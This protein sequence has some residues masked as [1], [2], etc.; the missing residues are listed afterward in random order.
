MPHVAIKLYPGRSEQQKAR[1]CDEIVK[2]V[3]AALQCGEQ[4]I[5]VSIE[6]IEQGDWTVKVYEPDILGKWHKL[7]KKP[8]YEPR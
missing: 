4:S 8:G 7:Y 5:S 6:D 1:L 3:T 2:A